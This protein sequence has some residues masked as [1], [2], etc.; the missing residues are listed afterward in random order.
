MI[1][2]LKSVEVMVKKDEPD[3]VAARLLKYIA[4]LE[5]RGGGGSAV[6]IIR[7]RL[8]LGDSLADLL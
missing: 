1:T 5:A 7:N 8:L 3:L 2:Q 6:E 4:M